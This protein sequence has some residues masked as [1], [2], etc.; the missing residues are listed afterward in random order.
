M[1]EEHCETSARAAPHKEAGNPVPARRPGV[2]A[3]N[4]FLLALGVL[5]LGTLREG[6]CKL[7][8]GLVRGECVRGFG[9]QE[10]QFGRDLARA[11]RAAEQATQLAE[12]QPVHLAAGRT[13]AGGRVT[14]SF[15]HEKNADHKTFITETKEFLFKIDSSSTFQ[16]C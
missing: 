7:S 10:G 16:P 11:R 2:E 9:G 3:L 14:L 5:P 15:A 4:V 1:G 13:R 8:S 12:T 6:Q